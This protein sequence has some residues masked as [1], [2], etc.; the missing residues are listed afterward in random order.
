MNNY[1][2]GGDGRHWMIALRSKSLPSI[3]VLPTGHKQARFSRPSVRGASACCFRA[4]TG[5]G[6]PVFAFWNVPK[7]SRL[8]APSRMPVVGSLLRFAIHSKVPDA[9]H[10]RVAVAPASSWAAAACGPSAMSGCLCRACPFDLQQ[11][12]YCSKD[13][14]FLHHL[15]CTHRAPDTRHPSSRS[16][17]EPP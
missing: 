9:P 1:N 12:N 3:K 2:L 17:P 10:P 4:V 15:C 13:S 16:R 5:Q 8:H 14:T 11:S 7:L 6:R